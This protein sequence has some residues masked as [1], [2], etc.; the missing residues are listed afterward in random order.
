MK[1]DHNSGMAVLQNISPFVDDM[2]LLTLVSCMLKSLCQ[3]QTCTT[4]FLDS[5]RGRRNRHLRAV[6]FRR[7]CMKAKGVGSQKLP[8]E[9]YSMINVIWRPD[10]ILSL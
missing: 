8:V 4:G 1:R 9:L 5:G 3:D 2:H 6:D 7:I 10:R